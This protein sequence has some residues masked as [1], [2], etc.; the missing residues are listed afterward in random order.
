MRIS[1]I[2][3][4]FVILLFGCQ[5]SA[6]AASKPNACPAVTSIQA[7]GLSDAV[8]AD[9]NGW[10]LWVGTQTSNYDTSEKWNFIIAFTTASDKED[11]IDTFTTVMK[12]LN[13]L[14]GPIPTLNGWTCEY[15]TSSSRISAHATTVN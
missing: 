12:S 6:I 1:Q 11:A 7:E 8:S 13:L 2:S 9:P 10:N 15:T 4:G 14:A 5:L 3:I